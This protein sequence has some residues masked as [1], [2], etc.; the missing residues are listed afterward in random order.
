MN[1]ETLKKYNDMFNAAWK[2]FKYYATKIPERKDDDA[3]WAEII[4]Q[5]NKGSK[6]FG[7][8]R[9]ACQL[10]VTAVGE[11]EEIAKGKELP[12]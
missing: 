3:F 8:H 11:I 2:L 7:E 5:A 12:E 9:F 10:M 1:D 6:Q 4:D